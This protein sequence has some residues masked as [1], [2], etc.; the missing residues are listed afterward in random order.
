LSKIIIA[1]DFNDPEKALGFA[2]GIRHQTN[3]VKVGLE[4]FIRGGPEIVVRLKQMGFYVFTDLKFLDIPNTVAGAVSSCVDMGA[5]MLTMHTLGGEKMIQSAINARDKTSGKKRKTILLGVTLLTSMEQDD[6]LWP[7]QRNISEITCDLAL[8]AHGFG[9]DGC[10][11][12]GLEAGFI[13]KMTGRDF[14]LVTPG[15]R[16]EP[17]ADDQKRVVTPEQAQ[18][19]GA[20][21]LVVG[22]PVIKNSDPVQALRDIRNRLS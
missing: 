8:K 15:I 12:S 2:R 17:A 4:L 22:R 6:L 16:T 14:C 13:R 7:D 5:D 19:A 18:M 20:D 10:V 11:C 21:F 3:W 9:L 1:L